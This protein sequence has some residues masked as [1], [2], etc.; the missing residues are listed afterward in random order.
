MHKTEKIERLVIAL[1]EAFQ[2]KRYGADADYDPDFD[3]FDAAADAIESLF[4][5]HRG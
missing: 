1:R 2:R 5:E 4:T 3:L